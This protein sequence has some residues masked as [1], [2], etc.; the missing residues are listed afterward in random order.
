MQQDHPFNRITKLPNVAGPR[1]TIHPRY[2]L[3]L[4][5]FEILSEPLI[6]ICDKGPYQFWKIFQVIPQ[7]GNPED[8]LGKPVVEIGPETTGFDFL[9]QILGTARYDSKGLGFSWLGIPSLGIPRLHQTH[10]FRLK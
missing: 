1:V 2:Q 4:K 10:Q 5:G 3:R 6:R 9:L 8:E 7:R